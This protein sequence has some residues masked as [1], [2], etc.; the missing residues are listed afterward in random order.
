MREAIS[1]HHQR[2]S[3]V[4]RGHQSVIIRGHQRSSSEVIRGHHQRSSSKVIGGRPQW[5]SVIL[6]KH[7]PS[8]GGE[9]REAERRL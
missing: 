2:S 4:I 8:E 5:S 6:Q 3:E 9:E 7:S 1:G